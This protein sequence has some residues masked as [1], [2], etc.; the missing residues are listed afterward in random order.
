VLLGG[1][2]VSVLNAPTEIM[3]GIFE[4]GGEKILMLLPVWSPGPYYWCWPQRK[5][6]S[7]YESQLPTKLWNSKMDGTWRHPCRPVC[8]VRYSCRYI[9]LC[10][11]WFH[12]L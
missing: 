2:T 3:Y 1:N 12:S 9:S 10:W 11:F 7:F 6:F 5:L 8:C 4:G